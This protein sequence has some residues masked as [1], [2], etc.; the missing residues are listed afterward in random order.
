MQTYAHMH[1]HAHIH[2]YNYTHAHTH[3]HIP[4]VFINS[5]NHFHFNE[6]N[7]FQMKEQEI[8]DAGIWSINPVAAVT[9]QVE[10]HLWRG[11]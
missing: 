4:N 5:F 1:A 8:A 10:Q 3:V 9:R 2:A 7:Y 6:E 11:H